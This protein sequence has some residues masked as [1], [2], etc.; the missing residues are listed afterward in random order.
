MFRFALLTSFLAL[1]FSC[2]TPFAGAQGY[3]GPYV[4]DAR[5]GDDPAVEDYDDYAPLKVSDPLEGF[6]RRVFA[7]NDWTYTRVLSPAT[8]AY[9]FVVRP[10]VNRAIANFYDNVRYPVRVVN[11][12]LQGKFSRADLETRKFVVNTLAGLGGFI[13]QSETIPSLADIPRED[14]GQTLGFWGVPHGPYL[15]V[16]MFGGYSLRDLGGRVGDIVVS[17]TG[18]QY[19]RLANRAWSDD[20]EWEWQTAI[21]VTDSFATMP[22]VLDLYARV[23]ASA[24]DPY[25]SV[26]DASRRYRN[27][28]TAR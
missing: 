5:N 18:W 24:V 6:N 21:T 12:L 15:V 17:P 2:A 11:S 9:E 27:A 22:G 16:P 4:I 7:L 10:P 19:I 25:V 3:S 26:R 13:R 14:F 1:V 23:K 28:E 20:L 8:K